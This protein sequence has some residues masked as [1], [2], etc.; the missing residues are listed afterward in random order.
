MTSGDFYS[1][2]ISFNESSLELSL[3]S[4]FDYE[5]ERMV[6]INIACYVTYGGATQAYPRV[7]TLNIHDVDDNGPLI[8]KY[9]MQTTSIQ[10]TE[11]RQQILVRPK[12]GTLLK[13]HYYFIGPLLT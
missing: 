10:Y 3:T 2:H 13:V 5:V 12:D 4:P 11:S 7:F 9:T 8:I 6:R 1:S